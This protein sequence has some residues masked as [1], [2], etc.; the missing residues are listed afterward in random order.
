MKQNW[1]IMDYGCQNK[2]K[3]IIPKMKWSRLALGTNSYTRSL[4]LPSRQKPRSLTRLRCWSLATS[5]TSF[6]NSR[7]PWPEPMDNLFTAMS[8]PL[9]S[10]PWIVHQKVIFQWRIIW[11]LVAYSNKSII[12][13]LCITLYY[14][15]LPCKQDQ[16]HPGQAYWPQKSHLWPL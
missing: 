7:S 2:N 12:N 5:I 16:I 15:T 6:L 4:S 14:K 10:V 8:C 9:E 3:K 11:G 1:S 13:C